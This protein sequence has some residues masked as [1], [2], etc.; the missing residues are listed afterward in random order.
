MRRALIIVLVLLC[1][2]AHSFGQRH[3]VEEYEF[4]SYLI[5]S[6]L[7]RDALTLTHSFD[8]NYTPAALDTLRYLK[9]WTLYH[10]QRF[11]QAAATLG[12]VGTTSP[13][14]PKS[15]LF[16]S[17]CLL[18]SG[19]IAGAKQ[20]LS[21]FAATPAAEPYREI[22]AFQREGIALLEGNIEEYHRWRQEINTESFAFGDEQLMLD[23]VAANRPGNKKPWVAG[24][25]SAV[26]P[27]LGQIYAGNVGEGVASFL[28]VGA[29][30]ALTA[31]SWHKA[32]T[33][34][35]WR[36][37]TYGTVGSLLYIGNIFGSVASVRVYH[38]R[39]ETANEKAVMYSIH[40]P[41]RSIFE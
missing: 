39:I 21:E 4:G 41:L 32:E 31:T 20:R 24:V 5:G 1:S 25:A 13:F 29:F 8:D 2:V 3:A 23:R 27:G 15:A 40:I 17:L 16:G 36:T 35:N 30:A 34:L 22:V 18:E 38:Q 10:N 7:M 9:G 6:G 11:S 19:D 14:W 33:P 26:V 28:A 37:I 12:T